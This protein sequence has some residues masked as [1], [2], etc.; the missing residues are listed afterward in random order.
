MSRTDAHRPW[1]VQ[2]SDPTLRHEY[3]VACDHRT[4][5]CDLAA[6][7]ADPR[8]DFRA[9]RC[10]LVYVADRSLCGCRICTGQDWRARC[11]REARTEWRRLRHR[12]LRGGEQP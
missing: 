5:P 2:Q 6:R 9:T 7:L 8:L 4:G 11:R 3:R 1:W 10:H 12:L